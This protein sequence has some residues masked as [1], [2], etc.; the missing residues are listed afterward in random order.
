MKI[1]ILARMSTGF[2]G[3]TAD[4][5]PLGGSESALL[6]LSRELAKLGHKVV[7]YNNCGKESGMFNNVDYR[8]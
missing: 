7:I 8:Q 5:K 6:Y 1:L 4:K 2:T 3:D